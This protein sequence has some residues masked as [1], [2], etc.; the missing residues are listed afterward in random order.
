MSG[1]AV[2][3]FVALDVG[4]VE[5][6]ADLHFDE[7][8]QGVAGV[9][10]AMLLARGDEQRFTGCKLQ[11]FVFPDHFCGALDHRPGF[12]VVLVGLQAEPLAGGHFEAFDLKAR[13]SFQ[14]GE[15]PPR[16]LLRGGRPGFP[17]SF[18]LQR[19]GHL[20]HVLSP[21]LA[22]NQQGVG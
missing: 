22:A 20:F 6:G 12:A 13:A 17:A 16:F 2:F 18:A 3:I 15:P 4:F 8:Q 11:G 10:Q 21:F 9:A 14:N 5:A 1:A 7:N 19:L